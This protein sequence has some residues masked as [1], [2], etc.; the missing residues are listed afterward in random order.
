LTRLRDF[1]GEF[2]SNLTGSV[3]PH[4]YWLRNEAEW[5]YIRWNEDRFVYLCFLV[6]GLLSLLL[7]IPVY[8]VL[9]VKD[10]LQEVWYVDE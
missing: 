5:Q 3:Y 6:F 9:S 2:W 1:P 10:A 7:A 8:T 4:F